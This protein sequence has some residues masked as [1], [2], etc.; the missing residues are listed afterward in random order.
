MDSKSLLKFFFADI[1]PCLIIVTILRW[2][3][4]EI[5]TVP[6]GS[7]ERTIMPD[8]YVIISKLHYG[9]RITMTPLQVPLTHQ[10]THLLKIKSYLEWIKIPYFRLPGFSKIKR[11]DIVSFNNPE[12]IFLPVDIRT[13]YIKRCIGLPGEEIKM[14]NNKVYINNEEIKNCEKSIAQYTF[15]CEQILPESFFKMHG[16]NTHF[17]KTGYNEYIIELEEKQKED[18]LKKNFLPNIKLFSKKPTKTKLFIEDANY[19]DITNW[20]PIKIPHKGMKI[21]IN[22]ETLALY[23]NTIINYDHNKK[24]C[25]IKGNELYIDG[26]KIDE[27][28]FKQDYFFMIG[29][30]RHGSVDSRFWGFVPEDHIH[31]KC[32]SIF[33]FY[34]LVLIIILILFL[35]FLQDKI[36]RFIIETIKK[37]KKSLFH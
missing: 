37:I 2:G 34:I 19:K 1:M 28:I 13:F 16:I 9:P 33:D 18:F 30:N 6:T 26:Q 14:I 25:E 35:F 23:G 21:N 17:Y 32:I 20:G 5:S 15:T 24:K 31:G 11:N 10:K 27:Y 12:E 8:D 4:G 36:F 29:D 22:K 7:M 3:V